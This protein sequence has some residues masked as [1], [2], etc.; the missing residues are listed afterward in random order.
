M[1]ENISFINV[2][3]RKGDEWRDFLEDA[4]CEAVENMDI[5]QSL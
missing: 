5:M 3:V 1:L 4:I 2:A